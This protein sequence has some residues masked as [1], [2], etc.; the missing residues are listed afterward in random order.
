MRKS[1]HCK[2]MSEVFFAS[3]RVEKTGFLE[4][5]DKLLS[6][7]GLAKIF[8]E[9]ELVGLKLHFGE[10]GNTS[11]IRPLFVKR[12]AR[13]I[14]GK[15][16]KPFLFDT[17]ALYSGA[18]S[19]AVDHIRTAIENGFNIG[20]PIII[21]DGLLGNAKE[22]V[23]INKKQFKQASIAQ[24]VFSCGAV[25]SI[26]HFKCHLLTG[27]AGAIKNISMGCAAKEG[28]LKMHST[29]SPYIDKKGCISCGLCVS[30]CP[31]E[32]IS[33]GTVAAIDQK[34][35]IG[36]GM[37]IAV[38][39]EDAIKINWDIELTVFQERLA[40]YCY[41]VA[42]LKKG[43]M[44]YINFLMNVTPSCDCF[45]KSD[46]PIV[47]DIGVLAAHDPVAIDQASCD[48]VNNSIGIE[49]S[50]LKKAF[51]KGEDKFKD[52][53]PKV[54]WEYG[55]DYAERIGLGSRRYTLKE[56]V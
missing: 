16:R 36:C 8:G 49:E 30:Y 29:V 12:I 46:T 40:E 43:K 23:E 52:L 27:F 22:N 35:C 9:N 4:K 44:F 13:F 37:C 26:A 51:A 18:R 33:M 1:D 56:I 48:L 42:H 19:N 21:G 39:K 2:D 38:C 50:K 15:G 24:L 28:K 25:V 11:Y 10:K 54:D 53:F 20:Y 31:V 3:M 34:K 55:L 17:T 6:T 5:I 47:S 14:E 45:P 41:A 7:S 32:A